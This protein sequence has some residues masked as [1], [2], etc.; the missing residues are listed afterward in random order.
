MLIGTGKQLKLR[1]LTFFLLILIS[2]AGL[3]AQSLSLTA[4][5]KKD[6]IWLG[7]TVQLALYLQGS[8]EAIAPELRIP[9][10]SIV[11]VGGSV[12]SSSSITNINGKV[13][14]HVSR[15][16]VC[17]FL[18]TPEKPG[19]V[20]IPSIRVTVDGQELSTRSMVLDVEKPG[21]SENFKLEVDF[22]RDRAYINE[23]CFLRI[24]FMYNA[25]LQ[26]LEI[27]I[28]GLE[29]ISNTNI[30]PQDLSDGYKIMVN[31]SP[32]MFKK[33]DQSG[34]SGIMT[35][36]S[37]RPDEIGEL[38]LSSST[39]SFD[40]VTG[41]Q[42]VQ[43]FFGNIRRQEVYGETV[44]AG[45]VAGMKVL[46]F[47]KDGMPDDF[48]GLSGEISLEVSLEPLEMHIGDPVTL[49]LTING[50]NNT[51]V[52]IP[53]LGRYLGEGIDIPETRSSAKTDGRTKTITQTVRI[54]DSSVTAI[55][56]LRFSYF[57]SETGEYEYAVSEAV[58]VRVLDT[59]IVT[60]AELEGNG[61]G[62]EDNKIM[63]ERKREG[64]Y[65]NYSGKEL[66]ESEYAG[67]D[68]LSDS[69]ML[70]ILLLVPP[71]AFL[72]ILIYTWLLPQVR[73]RVEVRADRKR[74]LRK[75]KK[76]AGRADAADPEKFLKSFNKELTDFLKSYGTAE[77][78]RRLSQVRELINSVIY[79][80]AAVTLSQ[81]LEAAA[82]AVAVL[83]E[84]EALDAE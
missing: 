41:Y 8:E 14:R 34:F 43:D 4:E 38:S 36:Y 64:I 21:F 57:D 67:L 29:K 65:H 71:A 25:S 3:S 26:N 62:A 33:E 49:K 75:L 84:K 61:G 53:P 30:I 48:F 74:V 83:E 68:R 22:D 44:L 78:E 59:A 2:A 50:M 12:N 79:G 70:K 16:Y 66:L 73:K 69:I 40:T 72:I 27:K 18:L 37:I 10:V 23:E 56:A 81:A 20:I 11:P 31:G 47:P 80:R 39:A 55:P 6:H 63:L 60:S 35:V 17:G 51:D 42:N 77:D 19:R 45:S 28:P 58:P 9:D 76:A 54:K 46:P 5:L 24:R 82:A 32:V 15:S 1:T 52:K 13:T 7:E